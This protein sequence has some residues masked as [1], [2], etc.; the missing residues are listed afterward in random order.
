MTRAKV[1]FRIAL[2]LLP[3][4]P[5]GAAACSTTGRY[6]SLAQR[7]VERVSGS[8]AP[9]QADAEPAIPAM[10]PAS[11]DLVTRLAGLVKVAEGADAQFQANRPAAERAAAA[12][13]DTG[14]DSWASAS[15]AL[16]RLETSRSAAMTALAELDTLYADAR[17]QS[18]LEESPSSTAIGEARAR[19]AALVDAQDAT[20]RKLATR[21][22]T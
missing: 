5:L 11:A 13:G 4:L 2:L 17:E 1:R 3:V 16:A 15:V 6:P 10:P 14:S 19:V 18:P 21:L 12:A 9:A 22:R 7:D 8:A 20:L